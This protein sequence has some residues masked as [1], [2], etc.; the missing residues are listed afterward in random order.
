[1]YDADQPIKNRSQDKLG[2]AQFAISLARCL[3][4][5]NDPDSMAV[6]AQARRL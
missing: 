1:M 4:N 2:R 3:L 6:G 5:H